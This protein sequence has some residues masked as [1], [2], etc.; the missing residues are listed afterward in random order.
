[1]SASV[2]IELQRDAL[3]RNVPVTDLLRKALVVARKLKITELEV[4]IN[5]E[6]SGYVDAEDIPDYRMIRG[7]VKG[8]NPYH[9]WQPIVFSDAEIENML[10][11]T[12]NPQAI[13][14]I[15]SLISNKKDSGG[16]LQM[17]FP[18]H[19]QEKICHAIRHSTE[20]TLIVQRPALV[21]I[22]DAVRTIVLNWA[23][24]LEED[25]ILGEGLSFTVSEKEEVSKHSYNINNFYGSVH[26]SQI[27]QGSSHSSHTGNNSGRI[28]I[29]TYGSRRSRRRNCC[30]SSGATWENIAGQ[31]TI[32]KT[33]RGR[34][35]PQPR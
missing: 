19:V 30:T 4:W 1:M 5:K 11:E 26:G 22:V 13:S 21:R 15:E 10:S 6:L 32:G 31:L 23:L 2:V 3:D 24:K 29:N 25:G 8:W 33:R 16:T 28:K 27:A 14:E 9:G 7:Q 34:V 20:I 35:L 18:S 12:Q 17:P